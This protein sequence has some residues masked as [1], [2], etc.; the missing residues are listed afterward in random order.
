MALFD[1]HDIFMISQGPMEK[2]VDDELCKTKLFEIVMALK[3]NDLEMVPQ[4]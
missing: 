3:E 4:S 1:R 2:Y